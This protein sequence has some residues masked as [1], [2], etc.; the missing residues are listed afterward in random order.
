MI[1]SLLFLVFLFLIAIIYLIVAILHLK[2]LHQKHLRELGGIIDGLRMQQALLHDKV[3]ISSNFYTTYRNDMKT[4]GD[5][6]VQ[7]QKSFVEIISN[8]NIK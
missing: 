2:Q 7:L 8:K 3:S 1:Y 5:E 6:V 4:L